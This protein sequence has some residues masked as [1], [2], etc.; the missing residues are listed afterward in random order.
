MERRN[1][2]RCRGVADF[3]GRNG[4]FG[5]TVGERGQFND[6]ERF[7]RRPRDDDPQLPI[8][9]ISSILITSTL[10][11][12]DSIAPSLDFLRSRDEYWFKERWRQGF[13]FPNELKREKLKKRRD[14][15]GLRQLKS[16]STVSREFYEFIENRMKPDVDFK[17]IEV[18]F[19]FKGFKFDDWDSFTRRVCM[20]KYGGTGDKH[21]CTKLTRISR[22]NRLDFE[23]LKQFETIR[24]V[25]IDSIPL[26]EELFETLHRM[27]LTNAK[28]IK[29]QRIP[30]IHLFPDTINVPEYVQRFCR[31][32]NTKALIWFESREFDPWIALFGYPVVLNQG[33]GGGAG[34]GGGGGGGGHQQPFNGF[35]GFGARGR[36]G[37]HRGA[38]RPA[39]GFGGNF[40]G[41]PPAQGFGAQ[42]EQEQQHL[43]R[44]LEAIVPVV[45]VARE[46]EESDDD[47][48]DNESENEV[49]DVPED[50]RGAPDAPDE[51]HARLD[52][53]DTPDGLQVAPDAP[54]D[55]EEQQ[56]TENE[57]PG[58]QDRDRNREIPEEVLEKAPE[59]LRDAPDAQEALQDLQIVPEALKSPDNAQ[60]GLQDAP[61]ED[62]SDDSD[63]PD[64]PDELEAA[65]EGLQ[66]APYDASAAPIALLQ[67]LNIDSQDH[68]VAEPFNQLLQLARPRFDASEDVQHLLEA[69][70]D[71][72][73]PRQASEAAPISLLQLRLLQ[74]DIQDHPVT[75][76]WN[77]LLRLAVPRAP[78]DVRSAP[79]GPQNVLDDP[80]DVGNALE[81]PRMVRDD[82]DDVIEAPN[83][84]EAADDVQNAPEGPQNVLDNPD[85]I[86][87]PANQDEALDDV[88]NAPERPRNTLDPPDDIRAPP[89]QD[90]VLEDVLDEEEEYPEDEDSEDENPEV[91]VFGMMPEDEDALDA[92]ARNPPPRRRTPPLYRLMIQRE[93]EMAAALDRPNPLR[94]A[95]EDDEDPNREVDEGLAGIHGFPALEMGR[96]EGPGPI[97]DLNLNLGAPEDVGGV[98][99]AP[100]APDVPHPGALLHRIPAHQAAANDHRVAVARFPLEVLGIGANRGG[101]ARN[102]REGIRLFNADAINL[103]RRLVGMGADEELIQLLVNPVG[104][105][106]GPPEAPEAPDALA[107]DPEGIEALERHHELPELPFDINLARNDPEALLERQED[108][109]RLPL[110]V[111][112][113]PGAPEVPIALLQLQNVNGEDHPVAEPFNQ[114]LQLARP[115]RN[116][117][118][119]VQ[120]LPEAPEGPEHAPEAPE[121]RGDVQD[122]LEAPEGVQNVPE[123][124]EVREDVQD[125]LEAPE[126][127]EDVQ[128]VPEAREDVQ[129]VPE[130]PEAPEA[131]ENVPGDVV[132]FLIHNLEAHQQHPLWG[133]LNLPTNLP[134]LLALQTFIESPPSGMNRPM[135]SSPLDENVNIDAREQPDERDNQLDP[136]LHRQ[137][138]VALLD[139]RL[140][141]NQSLQLHHRSERA[142]YEADETLSGYIHATRNAVL[143]GVFLEDHPEDWDAEA[144]VER[145]QNVVL[146]RRQ[147]VVDRWMTWRRYAE[148]ADTADEVADRM[149]EA[150]RS[151]ERDN[152]RRRHL[153][154]R[155]RVHFYRESFH[156]LRFH[157]YMRSRPREHRPTSREVHLQVQRYR[158]Y[159]TINILHCIMSGRRFNRSRANLSYTE[160]AHI[161]RM[162]GH[163]KMLL[164]I[165]TRNKTDRIRRAGRWH[166]KK[167][168]RIFGR[169]PINAKQL[170]WH[171]RMLKP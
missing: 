73:I 4:Y 106:H 47:W 69:P 144:E 135:A 169:Q 161:I 163:L 64:A 171:L 15:Y 153:F 154:R 136:D 134:E 11:S 26:S 25:Y 103:G 170:M 143:A 138:L 45:P 12:S 146:D 33:A 117:P 40:G 99:D 133:L 31:E 54:E 10:R 63:A 149:G 38:N 90:G 57:G 150:W 52:H 84:N 104:A 93:N 82:L 96:L 125:L 50:R 159:R 95:L 1:G 168:F 87:A 112:L 42:R 19:K 70:E 129:N 139:Y 39:M 43:Q 74:R 72:Q 137:E 164:N 97:Q 78:E 110:D 148:D 68:P 124:P 16:L 162:K 147:D 6:V 71:S 61:E 53:L 46:D 111:Y 86:R 59:D 140:A 79:E 80:D 102:I 36:R 17:P 126:A 41:N 13:R 62:T 32:V 49:P 130:A 76:P 118:E 58:R 114:L 44:A 88:G 85:D 113:T 94:L 81:R 21:P 141:R 27:D 23:H 157:R 107:E 28:T 132:E 83:Q 2:P 18:D 48:G 152:E 101:G 5:N 165:F 121:A 127:P 128:N 77:N 8:E 145:V 116:A 34:G 142:H 155:D 60:E 66:A 131:P 167:I 160:P 24:H 166:L 92:F 105:L 115:R 20:Y 119:D 22:F 30:Y 65:H 7:Q 75:E 91:Q 9:L 100:D 56:M 120:E 67:L 109:P 108:L 14:E 98:A 158:A 3:V 55:R 29:F 51:L 122:L 89:N 156:G 35:G 151:L 37:R 123:A